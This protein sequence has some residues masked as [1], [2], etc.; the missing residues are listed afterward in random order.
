[1][2]I[3]FADMGS[4]G[5]SEVTQWMCLLSLHPFNQEIFFHSQLIVL[6]LGGSHWSNLHPPLLNPPPSP[7]TMNISIL[8]ILLGLGLKSLLNWALVLLQRGHIRRT[9]IGVFGVSLAL[10][11]TAL[12]LA[13]T[14]LHLQ[15]D[16]FL[17]GLHLT[18][19]HVCLMVQIIGQ[20]YAALQW[21]VVVVAGLD[22]FYTV[23]Q[24]SQH[25]VMRVPTV[26]RSFV[27][28]LLWSAA[29]IYVFRL[30]DFDPILE[31]VSFDELHQ[32]YIFHMPQILQVSMVLLLTVACA[33]LQL[34]TGRTLSFCGPR[35]LPIEDQTTDQSETLSR[36][37][38]VHQALQIFLNT[39]TVFLLFLALLLLLPVGIPTYLGLNVPW[40]CFLN[41]LLIGVVLCAICPGSQLAQGLATIPPDSFCDWRFSS[42]AEHRT[43]LHNFNVI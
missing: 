3:G 17:M 40:L 24:R 10:S 41:S 18:R 43:R 2:I 32:C 6:W 20:V 42:A 16:C 4:S 14:A 26:T 33:V 7:H 5:Q 12:T 13:A 28:C 34:R 19:H 15:G 27:T 38:I 22:H 29:L 9:F 25:V 30:S 23:S 21:P 8:S 31:N 39:W 11:D 36:R 1:M 37:D 35:F